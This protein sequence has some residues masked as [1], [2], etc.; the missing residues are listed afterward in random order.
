MRELGPSALVADQLNLDNA[1][2][3]ARVAGP[4]TRGDDRRSPHPMGPGRRT[5]I[6]IVMGVA[7][8]L[9][10]TLVALLTLGA[11][12]SNLG[13]MT[14]SGLPAERA[15]EAT[16]IAATNTQQ[17]FT[18][19][20]TTQNPTLREADLNVVT[21]SN[22]LQQASWNQYR[23]LAF[24]GRKERALQ[25][26]YLTASA[27][28]GRLGTTILAAPSGASTVP[29]M[30]VA[31]RVQAAKVVSTIGA[32][33]SSIYQPLVQ[34]ESTAAHTGVDAARRDVGLTF[35][36]LL[37]LFSAVGGSLLRGARRQQ[38]S[39]SAEA[40]ALRLTSEQAD[41]EAS[42][43]RGLEMAP[44]QG[45]TLR[46]LEQA[47]VMVSRD[48]PADLLLADSSLAHFETV[49]DAT[50]GSEA[51]C[52]V[53]TP[54]DCPACAGGQL[55]LFEDNSLLDTCRFLRG[56]P[57]VWTMCVPVS[58]AGQTVGVFRAQGP[59][60]Q[61]APPPLA[62]DLAL[63]ARKAGERIGAQRVLAQ[64]EKQA[65]SDPL[66][67]L[68][69]RRAFE[70]EVN[71]RQLQD[72]PYVIAFAD[73]DHFKLINDTH[74]HDAGDRALRIFA[75]VLRDTIRPGD[76]ISRHGGEEF[77]VFLAGSSLDDARVI[78]D[79]VRSQLSLA[80]GHGGI[81]SFT[82]T[83]GLAEAEPND[84]LVDV[85]ANADAAMLMAKSL[86]RDRVL[87]VGDIGSQ[88]HA[89]AAALVAAAISPPDPQTS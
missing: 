89:E 69:N 68:P 71:R 59:L 76:L 84:A 16:V 44:T 3:R 57:P 73:L 80:I 51:A 55:R 48:V 15:L 1:L 6:L 86:G 8:G 88:V 63:V 62:S 2:M 13:Q 24:N 50:N 31:Y 21:Q 77:V 70:N 22:N 64:T 9:T 39:M 45:E 23:K 10:L 56:R 32:I 46:V 79:R 74:G 49:L 26:A 81:P 40:A 5:T 54:G 35:L 19:L 36:A 85:I 34:N 7:S 30:I 41:F 47:L 78:C 60:D 61:P 38:R 18:A 42:L 43:Q 33:E 82:V 53:T 20:E 52:G 66:T 17:A 58:I 12:A 37:V 72:A 4:K 27:R 83:V 87:A 75:Q 25:G 14:S 28:L 11:P 67:G 65:R 29:A